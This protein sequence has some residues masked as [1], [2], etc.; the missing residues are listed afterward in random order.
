MTIAS[1]GQTYQIDSSHTAWL[2]TDAAGEISI[3]STATSISSPALYLWSSFMALNEA[4][5]V[6]ADHDTLNRLATVTGPDLSQATAYDGSSLLPP[7]YASSADLAQAISSTVG[8]TAQAALLTQKKHA[9]RRHKRCRQKPPPGTTELPYMAFPGSTPNLSY[10]ANYTT[11]TVDRAYVPGAIA[12]WTA[13]FSSTGAVTFTSTPGSTQIPSSPPGSIFSSFD[14]FVS[15]VVHGVRKVVHMLVQTGASV[16]H[17]IVDDAN[18]T[19]QFI[20]DNIEKAEAVVAAVLKTVI[21]DLTKAVQWLSYLFDWTGMLAT[22]DQIKTAVLGNVSSLQAY[23]SNLTANGIQEIHNFFTTIEADVTSAFASVDQLIGNSSLQSQEYENNNPQTI[24]GA[25]G[26]KSYTKGR[27]LMSKFQD[28]A[29]QA[30]VGS[31]ALLK[32]AT[33]SFLSNVEQLATNVWSIIENDPNNEFQKI[34]GELKNL[35]SSFSLLVTNPSAFVTK[36]FGDIID[37]ISSIVVALLQVVDASI[38]ALLEQLSGFIEAVLGVITQ[39]INILF[40]SDLYSWITNGSPLTIVDLFCLIV[41]IPATIISEALN[42]VSGG[43]GLTSV[44][45]IAELVAG[46][47]NTVLDAL[48]DATSSVGAVAEQVVYLA[49][50]ITLLSLGTWAGLGSPSLTNGLFAALQAIPPIM[51]GVGYALN[52]NPAFAAFELLWQAAAPSLDL[53]YAVFMLGFTMH[54]YVG[55]GSITIKI[56]PLVGNIFGFLPYC[57]K[58]LAEGEDFSLNRLVL[59]SIDSVCDFASIAATAAQQVA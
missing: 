7:G 27:W 30:T 44:E 48:S 39:Q 6:Y 49:S 38:E 5:V 33:D 54:K 36:G 20:V 16:V 42:A 15:D 18:N 47:L 28:N 53:F 17:T 55:T 10:I 25:G 26:A 58:Y 22:K 14:D 3:A 56:L 45:A 34:P 23:I 12:N 1:G 40:S 11:Q 4:M 59:A 2:E 19:Y 43:A 21:G 35:I 8:G 32:G 29:S 13:D 41:A 37:L 31:P 24:F 9:S 57:F 50:N 52:I 51:T 46:A